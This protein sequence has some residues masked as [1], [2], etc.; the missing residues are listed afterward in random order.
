[1]EAR[2][3]VA[4]NVEQ[5]SARQRARALRSRIAS[6]IAIAIA[7]LV[8]GFAPLTAHAFESSPALMRFEAERSV[9]RA[10]TQPGQTSGGG[11][12]RTPALQA[13]AGVAPG[14]YIVEAK[15]R[16]LTAGR[17]D[18]TV[19]DAMVGSYSVTTDWGRVTA[20]VQL[21]KDER[22]GVRSMP[23]PGSSTAPQIDVDWISLT[24]T[25]ALDTVRGAGIIDNAGAPRHYR[26]V[27]F[28]MFFAPTVT[29]GRVRLG[30][31]P[32][33]DMWKWGADYV[34]IHFNQE[35]WLADCPADQNNTAT[36]YR[37]AL[38]AVVNALTQRGMNVLLSLGVVERGKAMGCQQPTK[39][40]LKEMA[41]TRSVDLWKSVA[42][43]YKSNLRVAFDLFNEP[44][45]ISD[46]VWRNG[47]TVNYVSTVNGLTSGGT[48]EAAGMQTMYDAVRSTGAT[49]LVYVAGTNWATSTAALLRAP[50]DGYGIVGSTHVYC[51][52]CT[53]N[54]PHLPVYLDSVNNT[55]AVLGRFPVVMTEAGWNQ[56]QD[57]RYNV[58][59]LQWAEGH[60]DGW[61]MYMFYPGTNYGL[62]QPWTESMDLGGGRSTKVPTELGAPVW[63]ALAPSRTARG[64]PA[65]PK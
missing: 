47:G 32:V 18:L 31:V 1:M 11:Y 2:S 13:A 22:V 19:G 4:R 6:G 65:L 57:R 61:S 52:N 54:D 14:A 43:T 45:N 55:P 58:A 16:G 38:A 59:V 17:V 63:N 12:A 64:F 20:V 21:A 56:S 48:Y 5:T 7:L 25:T 51:N 23:P 50:L 49:N 36:T 9:T 24:A 46:S 3:A 26:G 28:P 15:V 60:V 44:N 53:A 29:N 62:V 30:P 33:D 10:E 41:D 8:V 39:P 35:L 42:A 40:T 27:N 34:R 37:N